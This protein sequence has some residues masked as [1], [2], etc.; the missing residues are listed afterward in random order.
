MGGKA[1]SIKAGRKG[2]LYGPPEREKLPIKKKGH[3]REKRGEEPATKKMKKESKPGRPK[4][5]VRA[6]GPEN[7]TEDLLPPEINRGGN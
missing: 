6:K 3:T 4:S 7:V 5:R 2:V 1:K